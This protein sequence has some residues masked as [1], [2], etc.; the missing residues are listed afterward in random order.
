MLI[1]FL[2][3]MSKEMNMALG[4]PL[5]AATIAHFCTNTGKTFF[6]N[7]NIKD[8]STQKLLLLKFFYLFI[9][10]ENRDGL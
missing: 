10:M 5:S 8:T 3:E 2:K 7:V 1:F 9:F 6:T 4:S